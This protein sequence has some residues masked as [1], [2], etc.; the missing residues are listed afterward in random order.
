ML[1]TQVKLMTCKYGALT[2]DGGKFSSTRTT[3]SSTGRATRSLMSNQARTKKGKPLKLG[4]T[5]EVKDNNGKLCILIKQRLIKLR[6]LT[7][8]LVSK[9]TNHSILFQNSHPTE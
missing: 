6:D 2:Q 3:N 7:S 5:V 4:V 1:R 8:N 9:S